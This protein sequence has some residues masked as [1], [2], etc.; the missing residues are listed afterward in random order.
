[1]LKFFKKTILCLLVICMILGCV[2]CNKTPNDNGDTESNTQVETESNTQVETESDVITRVDKIDIILDGKYA[3]IIVTNNKDFLLTE[4]IKNFASSY[5]NIVGVKSV[6]PRRNGAYDAEKAEILVG[7]VG[8]PESEEV[9]N[10]LKY[11]EVKICV[12]GNKL[13]VAGY[14]SKAMSEALTELTKKLGEKKDSSGNI[15]LGA[16]FIIE[17]MFA[18]PLSVLPV[19]E[20]LDPTYVDTGDDCHM[21]NLGSVGKDVFTAY[22]NDIAAEGFT[23]YAEKDIEGNIYKTYANDKHVVT[24]IYTQYNGIAKVLAEPLSATALP[25]KVENNTYTPIDGCETT[26]TQVGLLQEGNLART[27]NGMCYIIR[28]ADGS[29]IVVDG[30]FGLD[31]YDERIYNILKKQAPDKNNIVIAAWIIT[32]AHDDHVDVFESFFESFADKVTIEKFICNLPSAEQLVDNWANEKDGNIRYTENTR[33]FL[34]TSYP[35]IPKI[36]AHPGQE[37]HIRNAKINI[38]FTLDVYDKKLDDY[39]NSSVVFTLEAE[40]KK[41][42]FL[43]DHDDKGDTISRMYGASTLKSDIVQVAHHGLPENSSN[44][45]CK[46]IDPEYAFWPVGAKVVKGDVVLFEVEANKYIVAL[47]E[48]KIFIAEDNVYVFKLKDS[49]VMKYDSVSDYLGN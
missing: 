17:R 5:A 39:N 48:D 31:G 13:V 19:L 1:M 33:K 3:N 44:A 26:I 34:D 8:Y 15:S 22:C 20:G 41:M 11:N 4:A 7:K 10:T 6:S 23:L 25:T 24:A 29:F 35:N 2:S 43:G 27:Y 40:G 47:G 45:I 21:L 38:L 36:K 32:H 46:I 18:T 42:I 16:D 12:V 37:F 49:T 28:L 30:G 14:D 9:Y